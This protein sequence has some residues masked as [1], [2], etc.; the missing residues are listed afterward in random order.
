MSTIQKSGT[1]TLGS[2][3]VKRLGYGAMQ[4]AGPHVFGPPKNHDAAIAVLREAVA[5]GVN[6]IDT[7]DYY[8][9][10]VTNQLIREALAPY[11]QDLVIVTKI[12]ARRGSDGS[13]LP[14]YS[15]KELEQAVHDN[16]RNLGLEV[17]DVVN[18]RIMFG[19]MG[20]AEGS[21]EPQLTALAEL[22][23]KGLVRHIGL[24]NVTPAQVEEGRG[25]A[26]IV[27]VQNQYNL[28]HRDDDGLIDEL[29]RA[30]IAYTPFFPLGGFSPLQSST[31]S[32]VAARLG[33]TPLQVALAWL[34]RRSPNILLIP[35]TSSIGHLRENLA[36]AE[37][38]LSA[39]VL[40]ELDGVAKAA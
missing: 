19:V 37:L 3:T 35:G 36:A 10:H 18:L 24:S 1:F 29:A 33:A 32:D 39:D 34:L 6:H 22:Q 27:C 8:G 31:L 40:R 12:G 13:W 9:P 17:L 5:S 38:E 15:A 25:I 20:P 21:I 14:A 28:A 26:E 23:R 11:P 16:L 4:L 30:G 7:S 2:H